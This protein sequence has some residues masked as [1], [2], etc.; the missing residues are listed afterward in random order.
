ML[1]ALLVSAFAVQS[2][3]AAVKGT[4][5]F[6][7]T[8]TAAVKDFKAAHC[9]ASD[10]GGSAFGHTAFTETTHFKLTNTG[11][12]PE[13]KST[14]THSF[15]MTVA[16]TALK[17]TSPELECNGTLHNKVEGPAE[18]IE[19]EHWVHGTKIV[20]T[21]KKVKEDLLNCTVTNLVEP[22]KGLKEHVSL[23]P[24][25]ATTTGKGDS[26]VLQP[27][28]GNLIGE[29]TLT[30]S[31]DGKCVIGPITIKVFGSLTC[32]PDGATINCNHAEVTAAKTLRVQNA[33]S[34]PFAGYEGEVTVTGGKEP[35]TEPTNPIS[36]T[37]VETT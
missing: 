27:E 16:G 15:Q 37:T 24:L 17:L 6:T 9:K 34:G 25:T 10:R 12:G 30:D 13:T 14:S 32:Q 31:G 5:A 33:V 19:K 8:S 4:T 26:I 7:C 36:V 18:G 1:S 28:S 22:G 29:Y 3:S 21:F 23:F 20:C 11:V 35:K 2:A